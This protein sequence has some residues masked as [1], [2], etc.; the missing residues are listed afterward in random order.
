MNLNRLTKTANTRSALFWDFKRSRMVVTDVSR[1]RVSP[2]FDVQAVQLDLD[3]LLTLEDGT[4]RLS[5]N[6]SN[7]NYT[8]RKPPELRRCHLHRGGSLKSHTLNTKF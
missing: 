1:Q 3:C 2:I 4:D 8:L 6:V 7:Y 5:R